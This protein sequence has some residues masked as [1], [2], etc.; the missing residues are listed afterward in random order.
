MFFRNPK[1]PPAMPRMSLDPPQTSMPLLDAK[2]AER[3]AAIMNRHPEWTP[4]V[5]WRK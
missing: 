1:A 5:G 4:P 3:R 2:G